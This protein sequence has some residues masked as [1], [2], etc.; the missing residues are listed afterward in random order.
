LVF[1]E[2]QQAWVQQAL[3]ALES[4]RG[5]LGSR[6][7]ALPGR[8]RVQTWDTTEEFIRAAGQPGWAAAGNDG[9]AIALQPLSLLARKG[10]LAQTL[11]HELMHIV[12]QRL[13][14]REVPLWYLEGLVLYSTQERIPPAQRGRDK[15]RSLNDAVFNPRSEAEMQAAYA[16]ALERVQALARRR[17]EPA[18]WQILQQPTPEDLR[19]LKESP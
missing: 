2:S 1:P 8:I 18:L 9:Q 17:G 6:S 15:K 12:V 5:T 19:W 10:I 11:R 3:Q 16:E 14:A 13:R 7:A 4:F